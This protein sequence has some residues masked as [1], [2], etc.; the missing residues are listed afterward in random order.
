MVARLL[1]ERLEALDLDAPKPDPGVMEAL[2]S[3]RIQLLAE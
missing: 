3:A 1:R 2:Q